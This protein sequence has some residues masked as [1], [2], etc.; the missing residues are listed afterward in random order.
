MKVRLHAVWLLCL[1]CASGMAQ[2]TWD[3]TNGPFGGKVNALAIHPGGNLIAAT[4]ANGIMYS[5]DAGATWNT[6]SNLNTSSNSINA[7]A[8]DV[9]IDP[10]GNA[11]ATGFN[12]L[13]KSTD[14]GVTWTEVSTVSAIAA[15]VAVAPNGTVYLSSSQAIYKSTNGGVT[16]TSLSTGVTGSEFINDIAVNSTNDVFVATV[17][18]VNEKSVYY[19]NNGGINWNNPAAVKPTA[20]G[21]FSL[22]TSGQTVYAVGSDGVYSCADRGDS[23]KLILGNLPA[24]NYGGIL[25]M[26]SGGNLWL[27]N[28]YNRQAWY[29]SNPT[30][31][32]P[33][34][35][36]GGDLPY[37]YSP[38]AAVADSPSTLYVSVESL[39]VFK[40]TDTGATWNPVNNGFTALQ[41]T[42][43]FSTQNGRLLVAA[44]TYGYF[45]SID[46]GVNWSYNNSTGANMVVNKFLQLPGN[47]ILAAGLGVASSGDNGSTWTVQ[48]SANSY[49]F[50]GSANGTTVYLAN[51]YN[52]GQLYTTTDLGATVTAV[53][54]TGLSPNVFDMTWM[55]SSGNIYLRSNGVL[56][57]VPSGS[58]TA[59]QIDFFPGS[60]KGM[61]IA[62]GKLFM[63][64]S[65]G[66]FQVYE[67][68]DAGATWK[69]NN[70]TVTSSIG[71]IAFDSYN[72]LLIPKTVGN[73][74]QTIDGGN[75]YANNALPNR[76][77][78]VVGSYLNAQKYAY[79]IAEGGVVYKSH[80][81]VVAPSP[82]TN[83]TG[84]GTTGRVILQWDDN[85]D[86]ED[87]YVIEESD[88]DNLHFDSV[89]H[90]R[91]GVFPLQT[92]GFMNTANFTNLTAG[93]TYYFRVR[94]K[95][96]AGG[97]AYSNE[98]S[99][100]APVGCPNSIPSNRSWTMTVTA[101]P[102]ST[103]SGPGPFT[104]S[105]VQIL[106]SS[107]GEYFI[108][109]Y[110]LGIDPLMSA[111]EGYF[112]ENCGNVLFEDL[113]H[114]NNG[115]S[116]WDA[117]TGTLTLHWKSLPDVGLPLFYGTSVLTLNSTDPIP[118]APSANGYL[119]SSTQVLINY[120]LS[121]FA[122]SFKIYRSD[123]G[124]GG[125]FNEIAT[126]LYPKQIFL[127]KNLTP[128]TNYTYRITALN[129]SG[130]SAASGDVSVTTTPTLFSPVDNDITLNTE[131]Q[132]GVSWG[133]LDGDGDEDIASPSFTNSKGQTV[134]P[135]F[136]ENIGGG[137]FTRRNFS[138]LPDD[139]TVSRGIGIFDY[140]NDGKLDM[141]I[142]R[143]S[144][145]GD[146]LM[147][148]NGGW[149]FT[150]IKVTGSI[151]PG[152]TGFRGLAI[153]DYNKD[154]FAD[155]YI[156]NGITSG[157][158]PETSNILL[159][160]E[161]GS[162]FTLITNDALATDLSNGRMISAA[163]YDNDG[164]QDILILNE[165][166]SLGNPILLY[167][168]NGGTFAKVTSTVFETDIFNLARTASWG[169]IDND[170][171]LDLY[172]GS[173]GANPTVAHDRLYRND[174]NDIFTSLTTSPVEE[175][176]TI[177]R[178]ST[179]GDIDNDGDLDLLVINDAANSLFINDG[180][181]TFTKST[182][183]ELLLGAN[184]AE[185]GVAMADYDVD[186][187]LDVYPTKGQTTPIDLPNLLYHNNLTPT[188]SRNWIEVRLVGTV[189]NRAA[190]GARVIATT[191]FPS[192]TQ[193]RELSLLTGYGSQNSLIQ[194]FG[195]SSASFVSITVKW[196]SGVV[197]TLS[198][199]PVNQLITITEDTA[200]PV[201]VT[202]SPANNATGAAL[203]AKVAITF[204]EVPTPMPGKKITITPINPPGAAQ[205]L[206]VTAGTVS[207]NKI[208][209]T[210]TNPFSYLTKY[211]VT[212]DAGAFEDIYGN[213]SLAMTAGVWNFTAIENIPPVFDPTTPLTYSA[214]VA[215]GFGTMQLLVSVTD[216]V[217]V[218][219]VL[220]SYRGS[221]SSSPYVTS[222]ATYNATTQQ[223]QYGVAESDYSPTGLEFYVTAKDKDGNSKVSPSSGI[224]TSL[225]ETTP[226][227]FDPT[228]PLTFSAVVAK[229]F[230][231]LPIQVIVTDNFAVDSVNISYRGAG[232]TGAYGKLIGTYSGATLSWQFSASESL[233][234]ATGLEFFVTAKDK[235]GNFAVYPAS[236][237]AQSL[238]E[239]TPPVFDAT[240]PLT[241]TATLSKGFNTMKIQ[242][243]VSDNFGVDSVI[244]SYRGAGAS[245]AYSKSAL[246]FNAGNGLWEYSVSESS[247]NGS[248]LEFFVTAKDKTGN[249]AVSPAA[250]TAKSLYETTPPLFDV[251]TPLTFTATVAK[252]FNSMKIQAVVT[253]NYSVDSVIVNY[254]GAGSTGT[255]NTAPATYNVTN[256]NWEYNMPE[257]SY[258]GT[259]VTFFVL[260][261]D[262]TGNTAVYPASGVVQSLY[263]TVPPV[264][265]P[266]T[267][268][269][270][271]A[272]LE[273][274]FASMKIQAR[275]TDNF[276]VDSVIVS[277]RGAGSVSAYQKGVAI[278]KPASG[279]WEYTVSESAYN[280]TGLEF[281]VTAKDK[282]GNSSVTPSSG[283]TLSLYETTPPLIT[284]DNAQTNMVP[285]TITQKSFL[286]TVTD[287]FTVDSVIMYYRSTLQAGV[288]TKARMSLSGSEANQYQLIVP[289]SAFAGTGLE[290]YFVA[291]DRT[292]N[293]TTQPA[294]GA[295]L[296]P[297]DNTAPSFGAF[298]APTSWNQQFG[299]VTLSIPVSDNLSSVSSVVMHYRAI[300]STSYSSLS[301]SPN[302]T[303][304]DMIVQDAW[305]DENGLE[306][307]FEATDPSGN[308]ARQPTGTSTYVT[309]IQYPSPK[310]PESVL[311]FGGKPGDW[312]IF[313]IPFELSN[314][315]VT[316]ILADLGSTE[317]NTKW[318]LLT[319]KDQTAWATFPE[320]NTLIRGK[321]Y[322]INILN[323]IQV[324]VGSNLTG[325]QNS[326]GN[327]FQLNLV[328]GWNQ[329]GNPY[330]SEILWS[331]VISYN[332]LSGSVGTLKGFSSGTYVDIN[333]LKPYEG[334]FVFADAAMTISIPFKGQT[335]PGGRLASITSSDLASRSV[336][337]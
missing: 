331:D 230:S 163:D 308:T 147:V 245:G 56:Y 34:W 325:P 206:F 285:K 32:S 175:G 10:S 41:P 234:N 263:E 28:P 120:S 270:Y 246:T 237:K 198:N 54:I 297:L 336:G 146:I 91:T 253:D 287:N 139:G 116:T 210:P 252:G 292:G 255:Y 316:S 173:Q 21:F 301:G 117:Q 307:Y 69:T 126:V 332:G 190:L 128:N 18:S 123:T 286:V 204:D 100:T 166:S 170:G 315:S 274:G 161:A 219:S 187:F 155:V 244:V 200:G 265:D 228:T 8:Y 60:V 106:V 124:A 281:F 23:W 105:S 110:S 177:S 33:T 83:L 273:Q 188:A 215:K 165:T 1:I 171:D 49:Q 233:F 164:D 158:T 162:G 268:L 304:F 78:T 42:D 84:T 329:I 236:G 151:Y 133:D 6:M 157:G 68:S 98:F 217:G 199:I 303:N 167:K 220:V 143:S 132:Q 209:F 144:S 337:S 58:T 112:I 45:Y 247:Y 160:N 46:D 80:V 262:K 66:S 88:G 87:Y 333:G 298:T 121:P 9:V 193:I 70:Q 140:N 201:P 38:Y 317:G 24:T 240:T 180:T 50:I 27:F 51:L 75:S 266:T 327:L 96:S 85:S 55:D 205:S 153:T 284:F 7:G 267:P 137:N 20:D 319:Y 39:G 156:G 272:L 326:R 216:N 114:I 35:T 207:G 4:Q 328:Q 14:G 82:P 241:Y 89:F 310:V 221:G 72:H 129:A 30:N 195:L 232:S 107:T 57:K 254:R 185:I 103:A 104:S 264:F 62:N 95:N 202:L 115:N 182:S 214:Q 279:L 226:P 243:L 130:E 37:S 178:G 61:S 312:K 71:L 86:V 330:L 159:R 257:S 52:G 113:Y 314:N 324:S 141:Y 238:Y 119:I 282:T 277:Y 136:Y 239:T 271:T 47:V 225:Y 213:P 196:P 179:F 296:T 289:V 288:Y 138:N 302:G 197:Q 154:G 101:D 261:K 186:G 15:Q 12:R 59:T 320:F 335:A 63:L 19:S 294:T 44:G 3:A 172:V 258:D 181:G 251:A 224:Y 321:G 125:P 295:Y 183:T 149:D 222:P 300:T 148:N 168:N 203:D 5:T 48:S 26:D 256:S 223:W 25:S 13:Y 323:N 305:P 275:V 142:A 242:A 102:G 108:N 313:T 90:T 145:L 249:S 152:A 74:L 259:G 53:P 76:Y 248:G 250:G 40:S 208:T 43:I 93:V 92:F 79:L 299:T 97:S 77:A 64:K 122:T 280:S 16:F 211:E 22:V 269:T 109:D 67:S 293:T 290:Y 309:R 260:A 65:N 118:A 94:A 231:S 134:P 2:T 111:N 150:K 17:N 212:I 334:G 318:K 174:G 36:L 229:G 191:T 184:V 131:N 322:F 194:H 73:I 29:T 291:K 169:D 99:F 81:P 31:A 11:W 283:K 192:K 276:G 306:Y 311:G 127:D 218:D 135:V 227:V 189:S 278:Y 176:G 235:T